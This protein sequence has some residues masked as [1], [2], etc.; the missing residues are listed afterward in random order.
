[1]RNISARFVISFIAVIL[2]YTQVQAQEDDVCL[3]TVQTAFTANAAACANLPANTVCYGSGRLALESRA[4]NPV[5]AE[6]GSKLAAADLEY[7]ALNGFQDAN[8][9]YGVA[10]FTPSADLS[11]GVLTMVAFGDIV[12]RNLSEASAD[13]VARP[14]IVTWRTG[15]NVRTR[16]DPESTLQTVLEFGRTVTAIGRSEDSTWLLVLLSTESAGW[17][18]AD[19]V[20]GVSNFDFGL[21]QVIAADEEAE[22]RVSVYS[23]LQDITLVGS[24]LLDAPCSGT[25]DSGLLIQTPAET[26]ASLRINGLALRIAGTVYLQTGVETI[27]DTEPELWVSVLEG[28]STLNEEFTLTSGQLLRTFLDEDGQVI[29][30]APLPEEYFYTRVRYVPLNLLPREIKLPFSLGGIVIPFEPGTGFLSSIPVDA[31]CVIGWVND[32]NLR[33]GPGIVYPLRQG[34][35]ANL[36][37]QP[38]ARATG[39]DG[40]VWWRLTEGI[41]VLANNT[42]FGGNCGALPFVDPPPLP[43]E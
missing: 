36:S 34:A 35:S 10:I 30:L 7:L 37:A 38:D 13:F 3:T 24:S 1:M 20:R 22:A 5:F 26:S 12:V 23:A 11:E 19:L 14:V 18:S 9:G 28:E 33:A 2:L 29:E 27:N 6:P 31:A 15:A 41:W 17:V 39:L 8:T 21:L 16:P 40:Q 4:E 42:V 43:E 32:V 25:P